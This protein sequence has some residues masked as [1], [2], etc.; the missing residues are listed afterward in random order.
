MK[1]RILLV[2]LCFL[3]GPLG[4]SETTAPGRAETEEAY[5][6]PVIPRHSFTFNG[7]QISA[8]LPKTDHEILQYVCIQRERRGSLPKGQFCSNW[9]QFQKRVDAAAAAIGL[10]APILICTALKES[11]FVPQNNVGTGNG[12][13][14]IITQTA[15]HLE[16][17]MKTKSDWQDQWATYRNA[18]G[19]NP[20]WR[21]FNTRNIISS[22]INPTQDIIDVQF[23]AGLIYHR[24]QVKPGSAEET[25]VAALALNDPLLAYDVLST[26]YQRPSNGENQLNRLLR[27][28]QGGQQG[29]KPASNSYFQDVKKCLAETN[30]PLVNESE[31]PQECQLNREGRICQPNL[32]SSLSY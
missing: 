15:G 26:G 24:L 11:K 20:N 4:W 19:R 7:Q 2:I 9:P 1:F 16:R 3:P 6:R 27:W 12:Y 31:I 22:S 25:G 13:L 28:I 32:Q 10:P 29:R 21:V 5:A 30:K 14:Q 18:L 17:E 23:F 8:H